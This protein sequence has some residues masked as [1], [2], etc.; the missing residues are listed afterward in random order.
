MKELARTPVRDATVN[1]EPYG[2]LTIRFSTDPFPPLPT[3]TITL[4]FM[5][6][7]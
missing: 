1:L 4:N 5:P 3:G 7:T 6:T 2:L